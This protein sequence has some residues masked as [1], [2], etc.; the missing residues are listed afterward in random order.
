MKNYVQ[1]HNTAKQGR[2]VRDPER[3][4]IHAKKSIRHLLGNKAWLISGEGIRAPKAYY[5]RY[6]FTVQEVIAGTP[7]RAIGTTGQ[8]FDFSIPLSAE[9]WFKDFLESQQNFSLGVREIPDD[10]LKRL[11]ELSRIARP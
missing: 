11:E 5:L 10:F 9:P 7:N 1:Y 3:F 2:L 4:H 8:D 6:T